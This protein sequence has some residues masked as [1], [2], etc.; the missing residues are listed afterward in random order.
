MHLSTAIITAP[1]RPE[2]TLAQS[3]ASFRAAG[4]DC[5][6]HISAELSFRIGRDLPMAWK[7]TASTNNPPLGNFRNWVRALEKIYDFTKSEWLMVCEDD[8][9]WAAGAAATLAADLASLP[10]QTDDWKQHAGALSLYLPHRMARDREAQRGKLGKG[11]HHE[12]MQFGLNTWGAQCYLFS[13]AMAGA[14]LG[15]RLLQAYLDDERWQKNVDAII[16]DCLARAGRLIIYR[17][18]CLVD[19]AGEANSSLGNLKDRADLRTRY[20]TP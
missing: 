15:D 9:V 18:P 16:G 8:I 2:P 17:V 1:A 20:F 6:V 14:L 4:F 13:R 10:I 7:V 3:Y 11:W 12:L 5:N 19:H